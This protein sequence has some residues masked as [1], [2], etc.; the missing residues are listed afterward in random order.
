MFCI[1]QN[2]FFSFFQT[3]YEHQKRRVAEK[4][5][6]VDERTKTDESCRLIIWHLQPSLVQHLSK[7]SLAPKQDLQAQLRVRLKPLTLK[8]H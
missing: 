8:I 4:G 5:L 3:D 1:P 7:L 2:V 6:S